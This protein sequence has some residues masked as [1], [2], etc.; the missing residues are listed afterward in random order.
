VLTGDADHDMAIL[1]INHHQSAVDMAQS[2]Q[3]HGQHDEL[4]EMPTKM[5][6]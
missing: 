4:K 3:H 1:M 2:L 5:I 6:E